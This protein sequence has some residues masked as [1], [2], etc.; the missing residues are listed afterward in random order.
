M[1]RRYSPQAKNSNR[2][3]QENSEHEGLGYESNN[4][5][6]LAKFRPVSELESTQTPTH[7]ARRSLKN[8]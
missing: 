6:L 1:A 8:A 5:F 3:H 4:A 2:S 7:F